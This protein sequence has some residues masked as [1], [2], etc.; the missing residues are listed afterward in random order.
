MTDVAVAKA[1]VFFIVGTFALGAMFVMG[2]YVIDTLNDNITVYYPNVA[3]VITATL[4]AIIALSIIFFGLKQS[5][6][7]GGTRY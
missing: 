6:T 3:L 7:K 1:V 4:L 5:M 2:T